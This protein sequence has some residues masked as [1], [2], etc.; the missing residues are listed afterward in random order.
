[1]S[2]FFRTA[3]PDLRDLFALRELLKPF[4]HTQRLVNDGHVSVELNVELN[5]MWKAHTH[6]HLDAITDLHQC[7]HDRNY[8]NRATAAWNDFENRMPT[9]EFGFVGED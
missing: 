8:L 6:E 1:M 7:A 9:A 5:W 4:S 2:Q 3:P